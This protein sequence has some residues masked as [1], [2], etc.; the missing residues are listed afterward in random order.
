MQHVVEHE[1]A[2][3]PE[4]RRRQL[5][6]VRQCGPGVLAVDVEEADRAAAE[7]G[8]DVLRAHVTAVDLPR[9]PPLGRNAVAV[10]VVLEA[11]AHGRSGPVEAIDAEGTLARR[12]GVRQGDEEAALEGADL[13]HVARH[14]HGCLDAHQAAG[15]G[16]GDLRGHARD[17]AVAV[18]E[19]VVDRADAGPDD[20]WIGHWAPP[21]GES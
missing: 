7:P 4:H 2:A 12:Q 18:R 1:H 14:P 10:A 6:V 21:L 17:G 19:I 13:G 11:L 15:D 3:G 9:D 8:C 5:Q 20:E 16:G